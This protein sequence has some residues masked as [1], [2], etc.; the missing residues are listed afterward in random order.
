MKHSRKQRLSGKQNKSRRK[1]EQSRL[2]AQNSIFYEQMMQDG[3]CV[4]ADNMYSR[5][6]AFDDVNYR[7]S[8]RDDQVEFFTNG[9]K[10]R[11][12]MTRK[13]FIKCCLLTV[14]LTVMISWT[15]CILRSVE[16]STTY[17]ARR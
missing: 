4:L 7:L 17:T 11:T 15:R 10:F 9:V 6:Y 8:R 14:P 12:I 5:T 3:M 13:P 16:I 1:Q 2:T